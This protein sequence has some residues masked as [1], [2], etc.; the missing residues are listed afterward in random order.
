MAKAKA[1]TDAQ[2]TVLRRMAEGEMLR[3]M[4]YVRGPMRYSIGEKW[5]T[6]PAPTA[7]VLRRYGWVKLTKG[8]WKY[9]EYALTDAGRAALTEA[10]K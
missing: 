3:W 6:V 5:E 4:D 9:Q 10:S 7:H 8:D 2:L 1:P